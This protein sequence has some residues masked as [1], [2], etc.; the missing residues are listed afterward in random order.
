MRGAGSTPALRLAHF[1]AG[2]EPA[3]AAAAAQPASVVPHAAG[4]GRSDD[5]SVDN[6]AGHGAA[7]QAVQ[8]EPNDSSSTWRVRLRCA[9]KGR[10]RT[11]ARP[12]YKSLL[13]LSR[14]HTA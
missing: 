6:D 8:L 11:H 1:I 4:R 7:H 2:N 13:M 9:F 5:T 10:R 3:A 12:A 14:A